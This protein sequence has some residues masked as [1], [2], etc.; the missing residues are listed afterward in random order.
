MKSI[1]KALVAITAGSCAVNALPST[2]VTEVETTLAN[3]QVS[4][5]SPKT[6]L[7]KVITYLSH[8]V[9]VSQ[10][11]LDPR[12]FSSA[13]CKLRSKFL[14]REWELVIPHA[15]CW[16]LQSDPLEAFEKELTSF[17][18][19]VS[20]WKAKPFEPETGTYRATFWTGLGC[21]DVVIAAGIKEVTGGNIDIAC[22]QVP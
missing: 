17:H 10:C 22:S 11:Q 6:K 9:Q 14:H 5:P 13:S 2:P 12:A 15:E 7:S 3:H 8:K 19:W 21:K 18:C 1:L 4:R 20:Q 16:D